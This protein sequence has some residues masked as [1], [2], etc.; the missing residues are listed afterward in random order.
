MKYQ[1]S[2]QFSA[3]I[4]VIIIA[5]A[6]GLVFFITTQNTNVLTRV[7]ND[8]L[9]KAKSSSGR[10]SNT[11]KTMQLLQRQLYCLSQQLSKTQDPQR[12]V[13]INNRM[14][15]IAQQIQ[16]LLALKRQR[17]QLAQQTPNSQSENPFTKI[18]PPSFPPS[19]Q[20]KEQKEN[21]N[22][23]IRIRP[24][25][26]SSPAPNQKRP[27]SSPS[28]SSS[29][30]SQP[31]TGAPKPIYVK[32]GEE[33]PPSVTYHGNPLP[34]PGPPVSGYSSGSSY[35]PNSPYYPNTRIITPPNSFP[36]YTSPYPFGSPISPNT[37]IFP[38]PIYPPSS[39]YPNYPRRSYPGSF[40]ILPFSFPFP[41]FSPPTPSRPSPSPPQYPAPSSSSYLPG[42]SLPYSSYPLKPFSDF[43]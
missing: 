23:F 41:F 16:L 17:G 37:S 42:Y 19:S 31:S 13:E 6:V 29:V 34:P 25:S 2:P 27:V 38:Q 22:P 4:F 21:P 36:Y 1:S 8:K 35:Y 20:Q 9:I 32:P 30:G 43:P 39:N 15:E 26:F 14:W 5:I 24:P 10:E 12:K 40:P 28:S 18:S 3:L 11:D 7:S 33:L